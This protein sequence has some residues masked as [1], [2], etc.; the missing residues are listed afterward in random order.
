MLNE[1]EE[2]LIDY[3]LTSKV[4]KGKAVMVALAL[5]KRSQQLEMCKYLS[6]NPE[7]TEDDIMS[8]AQKILSNTR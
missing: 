7:A 2:L 4:T 6:E 3:L 8:M 5:K 1:I